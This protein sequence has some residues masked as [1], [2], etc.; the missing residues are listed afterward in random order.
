MRIVAMVLIV[1]NYQDNFYILH[2]H[3][4]LSLHMQSGALFG[5]LPKAHNSVCWYGQQQYRT[6]GDSQPI[7]SWSFVSII[8][9]MFQY[10]TCI[11]WK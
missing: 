4:K 2:H 5:G 11:V 9:I 6:I 10:T 7:K 3:G 1:L 8:P